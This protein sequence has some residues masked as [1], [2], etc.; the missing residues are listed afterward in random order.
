MFDFTLSSCTTDFEDPRECSDTEEMRY[1]AL[2]QNIINSTCL[3]DCYGTI[4]EDIQN[5][6]DVG[7]RTKMLFDV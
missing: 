3:D 1:T 7:F 4:S 2:C 6:L 5:I